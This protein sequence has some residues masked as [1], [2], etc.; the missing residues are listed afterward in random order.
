MPTSGSGNVAS[1]GSSVNTV[2]VEKDNPSQPLWHYMK[3][4]GKGPGGG[5]NV[6]FSCKLC[7]MT[8]IGSFTRC[9]AHF[10][11]ISSHG[12]RPCPK[13]KEEI[14][15]FKRSLVGKMLREVDKE[16]PILHRVYDM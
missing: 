10:L 16:G 4:L 6:I 11:H 8:S 2:A 15:I 3:K 5:G 14:K 12:I 7:N 9:K 13:V 1:S